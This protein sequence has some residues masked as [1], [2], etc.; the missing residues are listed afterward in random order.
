MPRK[1]EYTGGR[2]GTESTRSPFFAKSV[3]RWLFWRKSGPGWRAFLARPPD[4]RPDGGPD[5]STQEA[6]RDSEERLRLVRR[7]TGLGMYEIDWVARR[8]YWSPELREILRVPPD[9]DINADTDLLEHIIPTDMRARFREKLQASLAPESGGDYDDEHRITR[10]DGTDRMDPAARKDLL[11]GHAERE[12][13]HA[14]DRTDR[15]HHGSQVRRGGQCAA[16]L[17][18]ALLERTRSSRSILT[19][20]SGP[21]IRGAERLYGYTA[22]EAIG[23]PHLD[24][25]PGSPARRTARRFMPARPAG[26]PVVLETVR[27]HKDGRLIPVGISAVADLRR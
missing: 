9:V 18:G 3:A 27:R 12:A 16:C 13:A 8:R 21:G 23:Q 5:L 14:L 11:S 20:R 24:S 26:T 22:A 15:R 2:S 25:L 6:L 17:D 19:A 1:V 10:F 4:L 7:A